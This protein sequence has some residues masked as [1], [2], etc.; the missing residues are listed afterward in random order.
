MHRVLP[1]PVRGFFSC[2]NKA[3]NLSASVLALQLPSYF[4]LWINPIHFSLWIN[5]ILFLA[6]SLLN[7]KKKTGSTEWLLSPSHACPRLLAA[8]VAAGCGVLRDT[9]GFM[10]NLGVGQ[11]KWPW[12]STSVGT[13]LQSSPSAGQ[14]GKPEK[15]VLSQWEGRSENQEETSH[16]PRRNVK[17]KGPCSSCQDSGRARATGRACNIAQWSVHCLFPSHLRQGGKAQVP[18]SS[19]PQS[20]WKTRM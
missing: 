11:R 18:C 7:F 9:V 14:R 2:W 8:M 19:C 12:F 6:L 3:R 1:Q 13:G 20:A 10:T 15:W 17:R 16:I 5:P 4:S